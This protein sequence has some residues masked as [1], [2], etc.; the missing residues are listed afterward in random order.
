M[1]RI[2]GV[3]NFLKNFENSEYDEFISFSLDW[4]NVQ[5]TDIKLQRQSDGTFPT[6]DTSLFTSTGDYM[7]CCKP[8]YLSFDSYMI[9][10][11]SYWTV[12]DTPTVDLLTQNVINLNALPFVL[13]LSG[14]VAYGDEFQTFYGSPDWYSGNEFGN[15]KVNY[16][17]TQLYYWFSYS[18]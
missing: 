12:Y 17:Q 5:S 6:L 16:K 14:V 8:P 15:I 3:V 2:K 1:F 13:K 10:S 9:A 7:I 4:S 18:R 11:N